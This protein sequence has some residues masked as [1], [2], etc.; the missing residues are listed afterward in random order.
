MMPTPP[1]AYV[2]VN[3]IDGAQMVWIPPGEFIMGSAA[4]GDA[5]DREKPSH[6]VYLSGYWMYKYPVTVGQ[7]KKFCLATGR[8]M[9]PAP[10]WGWN[11]AH[12][13][14]NVSWQDA[15]AY[16]DWAKVKLPTE[17]RWEKAA[18]GTDGRKYP[19][20]NAYDDTK[21]WCSIET[22]RKET[23]PIVRRYNVSESPYGCVDM[24]GNVWQWCLDWYGEPY[25]K[26]A[27]NH[28]PPG[29]NS[30]TSRVVRGGNWSIQQTWGM[31]V[32]VRGNAPPLF[33]D[34][35]FGGFRAASER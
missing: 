4:D 35:I 19:W 5:L 22:T 25:Y 9:P 10:P 8:N 3:P 16:C 14:V 23:A 11:E 29:P 30:G 6:K 17:A 7:F 18:R 26:I 33:R 12:P 2:K 28:D 27:P 13:M 15:T 24:M 34:P 21:V 1:Q 31:R 32:A 20:G